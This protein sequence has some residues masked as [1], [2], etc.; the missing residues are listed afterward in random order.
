MLNIYVYSY[1]LFDL[2][3]IDSICFPG[4]RYP[5]EIIVVG[6][7]KAVLP[8]AQSTKLKCCQMVGIKKI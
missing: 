8:S 3:I 5:N 2:N 7:P 1:C 4:N 6:C